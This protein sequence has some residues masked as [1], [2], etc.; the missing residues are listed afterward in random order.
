MNNTW[1]IVLVGLLAAGFAA[2]LLLPQLLPERVAVQEPAPIVER[3]EAQQTEEEPVADETATEAP[4][5]SL[6]PAEP[7]AVPEQ[8]ETT[9][10]AIDGVIGENE[11]PHDTEIAGVE[12]H[13]A[14][15]ATHLRVGLVSPGTGYVAIGFDPERQMEGAN[16][17]IGYVEHGKGILRDD[18]GTEPTAHMADID[19]GGTDD[20]LS[21]AGAEW[22]DQTVLEFVIPLDSG[23]ELD[24]PLVP[25]RRYPVLL[26]YHALRDGFNIF[27]S[28]RGAG[29]LQ[30][31]PAP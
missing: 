27:H 25:G 10:Y 9:M 5:P 19:R 29:T 23:D 31:D 4:Q 21:S 15:D 30:L 14:N 11:Y 16:F 3:S 1:L 12:V 20:I 17:I 26:A 7:V 24:K 8:A 13:W 6:E 22:A 2:F 18:Y 28:R